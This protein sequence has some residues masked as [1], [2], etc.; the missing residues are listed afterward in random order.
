VST[1]AD[2]SLEREGDALV[3]RL[4]GEV[5]MTNASL[6]REEL[7]SSVPNDAH[8]LIIDLSHTLYLDSA[9]IELLFELSRRLRRRRQ[10]L[11]L[12]VPAT[13]PLRRLLTLTDVGAVAPMHESLA[14][15]LAGP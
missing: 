12:V 2:I 6:V 10:D 1:A 7:T 4:R 3:A 9:A 8:A 14:E 11:R 13:S 5:D 15:A